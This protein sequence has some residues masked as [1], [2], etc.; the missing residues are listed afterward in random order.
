M[1]RNEAMLVLNRL[2]RL[3]RRPLAPYAN[4]QPLAGRPGV[5]RV[6]KGNWRTL[7]TIEGSDVVVIRVARRLEVRK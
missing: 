5:F 4:V 6:R 1:P 2:R 7:F 3:A